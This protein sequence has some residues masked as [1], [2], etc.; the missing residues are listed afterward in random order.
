[1]T[2]SRA[3]TH[4]RLYGQKRDGRA[5]QARRGRNALGGIRAAWKA[6]VLKGSL[7]QGKGDELSDVDLVAVTGPGDR[8]G[9]WAEREEIAC[10][11]GG[12]LGVFREAEWATPYMLIALYDGP[13]KLDLAFEEGLAPDPWLPDGYRVLAGELDEEPRLDS[14]SPLGPE[15]SLHELDATPG[16]GRS[17]ST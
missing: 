1:M 14:P 3:G 6:L 9:L 17:G 12:P 13:Q 15:G 4:A 10:A 16:T 11:L 5:T 7:A 8:E 2:T